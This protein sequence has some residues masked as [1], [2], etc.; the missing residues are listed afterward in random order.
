MR[1]TP[2]LRELEQA[3]EY[4]VNR[5]GS[6]NAPAQNRYYVN[7]I[8]L[9]V[10]AQ[11]NDYLQ[12]LKDKELQARFE[13]IRSITG[14]SLQLDRREMALHVYFPHNVFFCFHTFYGEFL[15]RVKDR[16]QWELGIQIRLDTHGEIPVLNHW[17]DLK[18]EI[19]QLQQ[20]ES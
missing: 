2:F 19:S 5:K 8:K 17:E 14:L 7:H 12:M 1:K 4:F 11:E 9:R 6:E 20:E 3:Q 13:Y 16:L 15:R 18:R 10:S